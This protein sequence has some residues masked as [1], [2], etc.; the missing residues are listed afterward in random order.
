MTE[1]FQFG[2]NANIYALSGTD[3][4]NRPSFIRYNTAVASGAPVSETMGFNTTG[5][6][7]N[8]TITYRY[9]KRA[10]NTATVTI[11]IPGQ[12]DVS[13]VLP[14]TSVDDGDIN[15]LTDK[16]LEYTTIIPLSSTVTNVTFRIDEMAQNGS[17][18]IR[19]RLYDVKVNGQATLS[20]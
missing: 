12:T 13:Y 1:T 14:D 17:S 3:F 8:G 15:I 16:N 2:T 19:F 4:S 6:N 20:I 7:V 10:A 9:R 5:S 11:I 18:D